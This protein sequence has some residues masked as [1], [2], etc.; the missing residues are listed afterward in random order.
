MKLLALHTNSS[1]LRQ[2]AGTILCHDVRGAGR[3]GGVLFKGTTLTV[4]DL[5]RL[6]ELPP[7]TI[8]VVALDPDDVP[9]DEAARRI[10]EA[11]AGSGLRLKGPHQSRYTF[12]AAHRGVLRVKPDVL[13]QLN[14]IEYVNVYTWYDGQVVDQEAQVGAAKVMPLAVSAA[15]VRE[16]EE[17]AR[18]HWPVVDVA[19]FQPHRVGMVVSEQLDERSRTRFETTIRNRLAWFGSELLGVCYVE[20]DSQAVAGAIRRLERDGAD[21]ILTGGGNAIDPADPLLGAIQT[22]GLRLEKQGVPAHPGSM[23]W[24]AYDGTVPVLGLPSCGMYSRAT[25]MDI[26]LPQILTGRRPTRTEL[27]ALGHGG[28]L[29]R[30]MEFRFAP[31]EGFEPADQ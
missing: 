2:A 24:L 18:A 14:D 13:Q 20:P 21:V 29:T 4:D 11:V 25:A 12:V 6:G 17:L 7:Q 5:A 8:H 15:T 10:A 22:L 3:R 27:A 26:V 28:H 30:A 9:E 23:L 1:E 16:A 31:Y 19:P